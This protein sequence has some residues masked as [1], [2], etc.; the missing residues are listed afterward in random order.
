MSP[1]ASQKLLIRFRMADAMHV[2]HSPAVLISPCLLGTV[3]PDG[4]DGSPYIL[5]IDRDAEEAVFLESASSCLLL[6]RQSLS[7]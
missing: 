2:L 3:F 6:H 5:S 4:A 1:L 7:F